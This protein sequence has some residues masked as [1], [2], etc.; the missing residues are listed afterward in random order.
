MA[1][2]N[3]RTWLCKVW[4]CQT[5]VRDTAK[6]GTAKTPFVE[7]TIFRTWH[8]CQIWHGRTTVRGNAELYVALPKQLPIWQCQ[9]WQFNVRKFGSL[10]SGSL[11]VHNL[12]GPRM[13]IWQ[14]HVRTELR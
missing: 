13:E 2:P 14:Y 10:T 12:A 3:F 9:V 7:L 6:F 5:T 4:P 11:A 1:P 8:V